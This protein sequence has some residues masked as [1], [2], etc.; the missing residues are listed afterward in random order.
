VIENG[1]ALE[2]KR[3]K[4]FEPEIEKITGRWRKLHAEDS[5]FGLFIDY[6]EHLGH[7]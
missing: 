1:G 2:K 5:E 6:S 3:E 4:W 7:G